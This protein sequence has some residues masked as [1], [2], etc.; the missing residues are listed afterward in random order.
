M[1]GTAQASPPSAQPQI[2]NTSTCGE[3][4]PLDAPPLQL[5]VAS[6]K[7]LEEEEEEEEE[8][9]VELA[10]EVVRDEDGRTLVEE[11]RHSNV[12]VGN[13]VWTRANTRNYIVEAHEKKTSQRHI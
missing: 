1:N 13:K 12:F 10:M 9:V 8:A 3:L 2:K 7:Q 5:Y 4:I 11:G 6:P